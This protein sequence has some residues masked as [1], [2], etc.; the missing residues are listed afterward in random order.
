MIDVV[1]ILEHWYSARPDA[2]VARSLGVDRKTVA[3]Y[4]KPAED[5]GFVPGEKLIAT[6][7]WVALARRYGSPS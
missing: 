6:E 2:V 5:E 3:R 1:E 7:Q 4:T